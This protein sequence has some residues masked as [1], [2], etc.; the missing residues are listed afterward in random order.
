MKKW[1]FLF[2]FC[3]PFVFAGEVPEIGHQFYGY[4]GTGSTLSA[5]VNGVTFTTTIASNKYY[6][7]SPVFFVGATSEDIAGGENGDTIT[8]YID[9]K[10][11]TTYTFAVGG[12]TKLDFATEPSIQTGG[13]TDS[14][15]D[16]VPDSVDIC[17]GYDD[18]TDS[19][20]DGTPNGC[21]ST[22]TGTT[23]TPTD[24][25]DDHDKDGDSR[26][27]S[28][29]SSRK[30]AT[31]TASTGCYHR[32]QCTSWSTCGENGFQTRICDY[33]GNCTEQS[34]MDTRQRCTYTAPEEAPVEEPVQPTCYDGIKNQGEQGIDC[35]GPCEA[36]EV[37]KTEEPKTT[38]LYIALGAFLVVVILLIL[39]Y[40]YKDKWMPYWEKLKSRFSKQKPNKP[41]PVQY[42]Q[43]NRFQQ[44]RPQYPQYRR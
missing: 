2:I 28:S 15:G 19:D 3:I 9:G 35:G 34:I 10:Q 29:S 23:G 25:D 24:T 21:D 18:N 6:G 13:I 30:S 36:C 22:P 12:I 43:Q 27:S 40:R 5:V 41:A 8:F 31:T 39:A 7:Y 44:Y 1:I 37:P 42:P 16:G 32:W 11:N 38:W 33:Q 17:S 20:N 4:A 26:T 14:D